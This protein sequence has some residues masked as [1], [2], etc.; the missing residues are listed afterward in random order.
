[1]NNMPQAPAQSTVSPVFLFAS[2]LFLSAT[3][4]F[5]LQPM[6]GKILL[7]LLGG[8]PA[9]WNTCMV[10]YQ[11]LLF[12]GY[13][14]AHRL[15]THSNHQRQIQ[16]HS[17]LLIFS[18]IALP[19]GLSDNINPPT[20]SNPTLWLIWTLFIAIGV[21]F[22]VVSTTA[23]LLQKWFSQCGHASSHD[24]YYLYA[25]SNAGSLLALLSYPFLIEPNIGLT[26]QRVIWSVA[27][28]ALCLLIIGCAVLMWKTQ[29]TNQEDV[30][31]IELNDTA[32]LTT[33]QQLHW[34]AL[35][36]VPSSLLLGLTQFISTDIA[37]VPLL[38]IVPL[39]I[40]LLT[41]I[42]VFS[43]WAD[44][45]HPAMIA[46]QPAL[47]TVFIAYSFINP[48]VLPFW[49]DLILHCLAF[50]IA[51]M[52]CHGELARN[53]PATRHLTQFYLIM[54]FGGML[55]GLFNTFVAPFVFNAVYEYPIM[56][57]AALLLRP[58]F[59]KGQWWLQSIFPV[60]VFMGGL[61]VYFGS[62][63]LFD[64]FDL[65][66][67][68]LI[69]LAGLTYSFRNSPLAIGLLTAVILIFTIS[70]HN[71]ASSTLY[72]ERSFFGV[73]SVRDTVI[74]DE[75]QRPETVRE[76]YHGTTKHG[77]ERLTAANIT[78]PLTYYSRP[79]PIGQLF[80]EFDSENQNWVIGAVG[81]GA[82]ALACYSK[83]NQHWHFFEI[84]PLVVQVAKNPNWFNYL[85]RCNKK[86][87]MIVGDARLSLA[88]ED[89]GSF[90]L[91]IMDAFSSDAVPTHLLTR[92]ALELYLRKLNDNGLLAFHITNRHLA[93]KNVLADHVNTMHLA[94][95]LQEF[96]PETEQ[97][98]VVATDWVVISKNPERLQRFQQSRLGHWQKLP[99]TFGLQPWTDDFT[100][101]I[102]IWK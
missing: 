34:L 40:Y 80:S 100:H 49:L 24:P 94:A 32:P 16:I 99:L 7:P 71:M 51:V 17:A 28:A 19:V 48:A 92:E 81:L 56:I 27:Y 26:S 85:N 2:T 33:Q 95:L 102:G 98:L 58:G 10:F 70:L 44:R 3:L 90:D 25:A 69:L 68:G 12:L 77:A 67:G 52:V 13:L 55:G 65:I 73:L 76:L 61:A 36:F 4:M 97:P 79:G 101:I 42:L 43:K 37:S 14:Y 18:F 22:F 50:F 83:D 60:A 20:D 82:G 72:Q 86:A 23:P 84:D 63:Q 9:V 78:T 11:S 21:P 45:I 66:G 89:D 41:F 87:E 30:A 75:N 64:Y 6:F 15:S 88:K 62:D 91:L 57:V 93:I 54:S 39:T 1:M 38:W 47:L 8:T 29:A 35:A 59:F 74:A 96:K 31:E 5:I 46:I 53:R